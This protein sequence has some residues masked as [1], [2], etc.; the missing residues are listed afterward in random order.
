MWHDYRDL[1]FSDTNWTEYQAGYLIGDPPVQMAAEMLNTMNPQPEHVYA[2]WWICP[3]LYF[4][5]DM[6]VTC[7]D[8]RPVTAEVGDELRD[9]LDNGESAYLVFSGYRPFFQN[10]EGLND[11]VTAR[12]D[13]P[14]TSREVWE[15]WIY[16]VWWA[17][18]S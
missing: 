4:Y 13:R 17:E 5:T 14:T 11:E 3:T 8:R 7:F 10:I 2:V 1:E 6:E 18:E 15:V 9:A 16:R 12:I